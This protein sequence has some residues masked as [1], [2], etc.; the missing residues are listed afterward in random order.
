MVVV[1]VRGM[2]RS[3][4]NV[5]VFNIFNNEYVDKATGVAGRPRATSAKAAIRTEWRNAHVPRL[6]GRCSP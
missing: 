4:Q 2:K 3:C 1:L 5:S 6:P